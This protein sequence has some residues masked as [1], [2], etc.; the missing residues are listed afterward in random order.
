MKKLARLFILSAMILSLSFTAHAIEKK[1]GIGTVLSSGLR[2]RASASTDADIIANA[3]ANDKVV[4]IRKVDNWYL[5]DYNLDIGYM[6]ADH[7]A[8]DPIKNIELGYG[9]AEESSANVRAVPDSEGALV[10]QMPLGETAYIIGF[11]NGWYKV[12]YEGN[13]G[14]V[15]SDLLALTQC[16]VGNSSSGKSIAASVI[17]Y[18]KQHLGAPYVF[19]GTK[20]SGFDCSGFVRY[21]LGNFGIS[22]ERTAAEQLSCGYAVDR[23]SLSLG[24]LVFFNRTYG[25]GAAA[26]HVGIYIGDGNFIHAATG[27]VR[28]T[29]LSDDYYASRYVGARRVI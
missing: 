28:I 12:Q 27:G 3:A 9:K 17:T 15:R 20:P 29:A 8:F 7:L 4:I 26:T 11:N 16:P 10:A 1:T 13:L 5:V 14:Y 23:G 21:V 2:L 19:G 24:D 22:L 18:A 25:S 6:S